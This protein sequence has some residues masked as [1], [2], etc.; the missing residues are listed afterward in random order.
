M[1]A[2]SAAEGEVEDIENEG[3]AIDE[4]NE[5]EVEENVVPK[6]AP[7]PYIPTKAEVAAHY[8]LHAEYRSWCK[9][10]VE[11]KAAS[12][13]HHKGDPLEEPLGVTVSIDYCFMTPEESEEG[14]D[15]VLI[16]Y[17]DKKKGLWAMTVDAKGA[18]E[19]SVEWLSKKI[20]DSG[21]NGVGITMK[22]DQGADII[23]LKKAV[24]VKRHAETT[25]V[26]SP[27][28]V[29]KANGQI[30]RAI[31][32]WQGQF[33]TLRGQLEDRLGC[34]ILKGSPIMS[35]LI[36]FSSDVLCRYKIHDNGR[37]NYEMVTGHRFRQP[38]CGFAEKVHYKITTDKTHKSKMESEWGI[39]YYLGSNSRTLEHLIGTEHGIVK[40]DT[41]KRMAD[42]VAYDKA[43]IDVISVGY[44][45]YVTK[46]AVSKIPI[47]RSS[48]PLPRNAD[49]AAPQIFA[50]RT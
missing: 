7:R 50:R 14:M 9:H 28:R 8:P 4:K 12:R 1:R 19:S 37:T 31:R 16:G 15:A 45:E 43:C 36:N 2:D 25:M 22:S 6:I 27:V 3:E 47:V 13:L 21:Y 35:W 34:K 11:G 41:F 20:E 30:E 26:E 29:S 46:G 49:I 48:D 5:G 10:C 40:V 23:Q 33:R 32:T 39:G 24:S 38:A 18:T 42:D 44:R 17:D